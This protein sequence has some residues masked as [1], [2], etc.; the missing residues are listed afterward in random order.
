MNR[1]IRLDTVWSTSP[2]L[3]VLAAEARLCWIE[4]LC[5]V[6]GHGRNGRVK[7]LH[8]LVASRMWFVGEESVRQLL[9][10]AEKHGAISLHEQDWIVDKWDKYQGDPTAS[11][12]QARFKKGGI[13][14]KNGDNALPTVSNTERET[15]KER[16]KRKNPPLP[17]KGDAEIPQ[18]L[19]SCWKEWLAYRRER[20]L[21]AFKPITIKRQIAFLAAQPDPAA[22]V[23]QSILNGWQGLF[24]LKASPNQASR[25]DEIEAM[26]ARLRAEGFQ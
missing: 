7:A 8:P 18:S 20:K 11:E 17:P 6:K 23:N 16:E 13:T 10:A 14:E 25:P 1:Y 19:E 3:S 26:K 4:L 15:E 12:R 22:C 5:Y 24:E 21:P 9:M 2:W